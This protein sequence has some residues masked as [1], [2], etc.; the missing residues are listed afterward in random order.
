MIEH[1]TPAPV[2]KA[3][4]PC[5][6]RGT[7]MRALTGGAAKELLPVA[8][9]P[10]LLRVAEEC[11]SAGI[12]EVLVVT[13]PGKEEL[14]EALAPLAGARGMPERIEFAVQ[15][16]PRGLADAIR[17]G[18]EFAGEDPLVVA[19]PDNLYAGARS[20]VQQVLDGYRAH[21]LNVVAVVEISAAEAARRGPTSILDGAPDG[22]DF[23]I[24]G[25]PPKGPSDATFDTAGAASA[26]TAVGRYV[27]LP[28]VFGAIDE[29]ERGLA[30]GKE[31]DDIPVMRRLLEAGRLIGRR[32]E[33]RF[34]DVG[35]PGGYEEA[36]ALLSA[37][38]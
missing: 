36:E 21:R 4:I 2:R 30:P 37:A 26:F 13:A 15:P 28:E 11:A 23:R 10:V 14:E 29:V 24:A 27:F 31:L 8:G 18:R 20:G 5:G 1:P 19:L 6:G 38:G 17:L 22:S 9:R 7:R 25:I 16:S 3:L 34:L 12:T 35:I 33:G 32:I